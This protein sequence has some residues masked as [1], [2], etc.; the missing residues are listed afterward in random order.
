[1]RNKNLDKNYKRKS[2]AFSSSAGNPINVKFKYESSKG[3]IDLS[4][5]AKK[6]FKFST[7]EKKS[8]MGLSNWF[9]SNKK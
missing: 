5:T 2:V 3:V 1:V 7:S 8:Q 6:E 9:G 4:K